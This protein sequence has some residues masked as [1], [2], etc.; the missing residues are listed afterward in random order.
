MDKANLNEE[1]KDKYRKELAEKEAEIEMLRN[2]K[3]LAE[4]EARKLRNQIVRIQ[5][6]QDDFPVPP[7]DMLEDLLRTHDTSDITSL[8]MRR[9]QKLG[10]IDADCRINEHSIIRLMDTYYS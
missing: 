2:H 7:K 1:E 10:I 8:V 4:R 3:Y 5:N 6:E 9:L